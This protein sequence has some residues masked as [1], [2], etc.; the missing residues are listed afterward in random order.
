MLGFKKIWIM[1]SLQ[2]DDSSTYH[3]YYC[4]NANMRFGSE[5]C[6]VVGA[7]LVLNNFISLNLSFHIYRIHLLA[8]INECATPSSSG[9][10]HEI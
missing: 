8:D 1:L 4:C 9:K 3:D 5:M 10:Y 6:D 2:D 7:I